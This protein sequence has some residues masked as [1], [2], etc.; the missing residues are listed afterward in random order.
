[1]NV[2]L[3]FED[4]TQ[5]SLQLEWKNAIDECETKKGNKILE[6]RFEYDTMI[7][8]M[9]LHRFS[10]IFESKEMFD[11]FVNSIKNNNV[12]PIK[13]E[14]CFYDKNGEHKEFEIG[15]K[16]E[17]INDNPEITI[18]FLSNDLI[19]ENKKLTSVDVNFTNKIEFI[20]IVEDA[21]RLLYPKNLRQV[22]FR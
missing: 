14:L 4:G 22:D 16:I 13:T 6:I 5:K 15:S 18:K 7:N 1:M 3:I 11:N 10:I 2:S 8:N 19:L 9:E 20:Q 12:I 21:E 17:I